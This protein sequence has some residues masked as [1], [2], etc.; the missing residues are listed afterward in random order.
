MRPLIAVGGV[1][2]AATMLVIFP[3]PAAIAEEFHQASSTVER[4]PAVARFNGQ[5]LDLAR[6]W[7]EATACLAWRQGGVLDCFRDR[8]QLEARGA[9]LSGLLGGF[10]CSSPL[11]L[12][13]DSGLGGRELWFYDRGYW[14]NLGDYGFNNQL[15]SYAVGACNSHLAENNYGAGYWYPGDTSAWAVE[16][17]MYSSWNDRVSSIYL[18]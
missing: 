16:A 10:G 9:E 3:A 12:F 1:V 17:T 2:W 7:G 4:R 18:D 5:Q 15:S 13:E 6:G 11:K 8:Q 14:Q